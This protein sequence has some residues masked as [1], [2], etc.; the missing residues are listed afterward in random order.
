MWRFIVSI[1]P[2][3]SAGEPE[4]VGQLAN[5]FFEYAHVI[6]DDVGGGIT[7]SKGCRLGLAGGVGEAQQWGNTHAN[8]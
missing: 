1:Q 8:L 6:S 2:T 4:N 3:P 7:R 5:R